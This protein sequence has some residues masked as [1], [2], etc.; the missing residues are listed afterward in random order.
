MTPALR[1][2]RF[3]GPGEF[4]DMIRAA[5][6]HAAR[7]GWPEIIMTD[8]DFM[9]WP[10]GER[11]VVQSLNDWAKSGRRLTMLARQYDG[12]IRRHARFVNWRGTWSHIIDCRAIRTL[13]ESDFPSSLWSPAWCFQQLDL[14]HRTGIAGTEPARRVRLKER[15]AEHLLNSSPAFP[16]TTLGL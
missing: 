7:D 2:G 4:A 16:A 10:L 3:E 5:L 14:D 9:N 12:V 1:E 8:A 13:P 11:S 6:A 15:L